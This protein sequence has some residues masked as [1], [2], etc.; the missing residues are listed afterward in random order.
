MTAVERIVLFGLHG[1][2]RRRAKLF[3][4][5]GRPAVG[6]TRGESQGVAGGKHVQG[7][8]LVN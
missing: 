5:I 1:W 3:D 2:H 8:G 7:A 6:A 4:E